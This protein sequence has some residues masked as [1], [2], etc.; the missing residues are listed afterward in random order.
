MEAYI[1]LY[2][3]VLAA[4]SVVFKAVLQRVKLYNQILLKMAGIRLIFILCV[5]LMS[6]DSIN[7]KFFCSFPYASRIPSFKGSCNSKKYAL[8]SKFNL[9]FFLFIIRYLLLKCGN[10]EID[11][12]PILP[13]ALMMKE[14]ELFDT[15]IKI[16]IKTPD[17]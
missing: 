12:G 10:I 4:I 17:V 3:W 5:L 1:S 6:T 9:C 16:Y 8:T 13:Y 2:K 11:P 7:E 14:L 15:R